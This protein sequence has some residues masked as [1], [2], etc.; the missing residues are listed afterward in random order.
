MN[1]GFKEW[2]RHE[3]AGSRRILNGRRWL[4]A[5]ILAAG[6]ALGCAAVAAPTISATS[7][8]RRVLAPGQALSQSVTATG[9]GNAVV[10]AYF[11]HDGN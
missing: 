7:D 11:L 4:R 3:F 10:E 9:S 6:L 8:T 5:T 2:V 1:H